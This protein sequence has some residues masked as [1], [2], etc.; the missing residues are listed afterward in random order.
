MRNQQICNQ[1]IEKILHIHITRI[2]FTETE[3]QIDVNYDSKSVRLDVY[4]YD[5][6]G[7]IYDIK[8]QCSNQDNE[9]PKQTRYYQA[10]IDMAET[11]KGQ[12]YQDLK[13]SYIINVYTIYNGLVGKTTF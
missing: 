10:M 7:R 1:L 6:H 12:D 13:E 11:E 8:M 9:L 4:I 2:T 5:D 3:K